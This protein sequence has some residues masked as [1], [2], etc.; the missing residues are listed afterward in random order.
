MAM[1]A[2]DLFCGGGGSSWGARAAGAE[3]I[4]AVDAW[5][6]AT[7]TYRDNFP[8]A[9]RNVITTRLSDNVGPEVFDDLGAVDLLIAS[10]ECTNHSVARGARERCEV[11]RRSGWFIMRFVE[12]LAPRW[13]VLENVNGMRRWDGFEELITRL[14]TLGY[15]LRL[16]SLDAAAFGVPQNRRRLFVTGDRL[17]RPPVVKPPR[18]VPVP[19]ATILDPLDCWRTTPL[20]RPGRATAT[21]ERARRGIEAL[22]EGVPFLVV[23]YGS[24]RAG[25]WQS[26]DRPLRTLT[27]L[28]RFGLVQWI[29]GE[30]RLRMLQVPELK[31]AM[32]IGSAYV[33]NHGSRRDRIRILGNGVAAPVM[34]AVVEGLT[35]S[36]V[37]AKAA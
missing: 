30:P 12:D 5:E 8:S 7:A 16:Q 29:E 32:G 33:M 2:I 3:L 21:L 13:L 11:S 34:R 31:A 36:V 10:P 25:G 27:T 26:L 24:D 1:R 9:R 23:Y 6:I 37:A 22:G 4:G 15:K 14:E 20:F 28:D 35:G 17:R 19:A 18:I